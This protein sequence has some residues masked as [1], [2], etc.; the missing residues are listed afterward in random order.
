MPEERL[1][2]LSEIKELQDLLQDIPE[3]QVIERRSL[4]SRLQSAEAILAQLPQH[5][6]PKARLTFRGKPVI[7]RH[8][9]AAEFGGKAASA[10]A[11]AF[12]AVAA[13]LHEGL[14]PMG[15]IPNRDK[16]Q[17]LITGTVIGS[18]GFEFE[19]PTSD[20]SLFT[21]S[22]Q[23]QDAMTKLGA[24]FRMAAEGT[25]DEVAEVIEDIHPRAV[26]KAHAFLD[27]LVQQQAWC[28]IEFADRHFRFASHE[29]IKASC[30]R[31]KSDNIQEREEIYRGEFQGVLPAGRIFEFRQAD[32]AGL[33]KGKLDMTIEDPDALNREWLHKPVTVKL[34]VMQVGQGRPRF[35]LMNLNDLSQ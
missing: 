32:Q 24:L 29:Q 26:K 14:R 35:T 5:S 20:S 16:N 6:T 2:I 1:F 30:E 18:F 28:G 15:P 13:S 25:D 11:D 3:D 27:L 22:D 9:I 19:L 31:L 12:A 34:N 8:G 10:F 4:E 21:G 33:I 23:A 7:G 17:L